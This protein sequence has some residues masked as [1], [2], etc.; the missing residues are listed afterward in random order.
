MSFSK[1]AGS[2]EKAC[3]QRLCLNIANVGLHCVFKVMLSRFL[4]NKE[5]N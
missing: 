2:R 4:K 3:L 5:N 1:R